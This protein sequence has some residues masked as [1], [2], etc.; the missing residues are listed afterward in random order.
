[1]FKKLWK[2][3]S[4]KILLFILSLVAADSVNQNYIQEDATPEPFVVQAPIPE[5]DDLPTADGEAADAPLDEIQW[6]WAIVDVTITETKTAV[7]EGRPDIEYEDDIYV[8]DIF[9]RYLGPL[10]ITAVKKYARCPGS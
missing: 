9:V 10:N 8:E 6:K 7:N 5:F 4:Q 3:Y 2:K 1:M